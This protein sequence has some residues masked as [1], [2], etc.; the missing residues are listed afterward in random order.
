MKST[1]ISN[2]IAQQVQNNE[3]DN[4]GLVQIIALCDSFLNLKSISQYA[5][6]NNLSYNGA[7]KNRKAVELF[8][9]K[10]IIDND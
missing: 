9:S 5:K 10:F 2:Y 8:G 6:D 7:K 3:L 1:E 4:E